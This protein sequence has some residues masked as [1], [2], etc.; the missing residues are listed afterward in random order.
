M[1]GMNG[2]DVD[3]SDC[4]SRSDGQLRRLRGS[5]PIGLRSVSCPCQC[6]VNAHVL[7]ALGPRRSAARGGRAERGPYR[8]SA[9]CA[10]HPPKPSWTRVRPR[11]RHARRPRQRREEKR[12]CAAQGVRRD[13]R[14]R[15]ARRATLPTPMPGSYKT[16]SLPRTTALKHI[17]PEI[18]DRTTM[19]VTLALALTL[20]LACAAP[21]VAAH[22]RA[23]PD[24]EAEMRRQESNGSPASFVGGGGPREKA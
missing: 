4:T 22:P 6:R 16:P 11:R 10:R 17:H 3:S 7:I 23:N 8:S 2:R 19:R 18:D 21:L 20:A 14:E 13:R 12:R 1:H 9:A 5:E 15:R 24:P